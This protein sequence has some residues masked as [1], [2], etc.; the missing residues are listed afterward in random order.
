MLTCLA[1]SDG[2]V[3]LLVGLCVSTP[4]D[5]FSCVLSECSALRCIVA[6]MADFQLSARV[7]IGRVLPI[8]LLGPCTQGA[9]MALGVFLLSPEC[10]R[11]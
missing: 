11:G 4:V 8:L 1:V 7:A 9:Q 5:L 2:G 6:P 10:G 3:T